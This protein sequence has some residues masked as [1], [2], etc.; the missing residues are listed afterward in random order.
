[1]A[2]SYFPVN[3]TSFRLPSH[4]KCC[5]FSYIS[6]YKSTITGIT[7][8]FSL[9][10]DVDL[11]HVSP[12]GFFQFFLQGFLSSWVC[13]GSLV[14][15]EKY[16]QRYGISEHGRLLHGLATSHG[17]KFKSD[18]FLSSLILIKK[19]K[20]LQW[21]TEGGEWQLKIFVNLPWGWFILFA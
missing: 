20:N 2:I 14:R 7:C 17:S 5:I 1:M 13:L 19:C 3:I 10:L 4:P 12:S 18:A 11:L 15:F 6:K 16:K 8:Q 9:A 21:A